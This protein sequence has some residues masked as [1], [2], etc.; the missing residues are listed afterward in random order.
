MSREIPPIALY[1]ASTLGRTLYE[2]L[3]QLQNDGE[4]DQE[5][6]MQALLIFDKA[7]NNRLNANANVSGVSSA[8]SA[9][10][11]SSNG[12]NYSSNK[13]NRNS[14]SSNI[15]NN[16]NNSSSNDVNTN[17]CTITGTVHTY[18]N[19]DMMWT[20]LVKDARIQSMQGDIEADMLKIIAC[21]HRPK[22]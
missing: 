15:G 16:N 12:N 19:C 13:N 11:S 8:S 6:I 14:N 3:Q 1:R 2:S 21:E 4:L 20:L 7:I 5:Q 9:S 10:T 22:K 18:R 17:Q